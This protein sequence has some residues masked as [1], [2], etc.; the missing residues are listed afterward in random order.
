MT[1]AADNQPLLFRPNLAGQRYVYQLSAAY[2]RGLWI[3]DPDFAT[4]SD[5]EAWEKIR[6][7]A[8]FAAL[9]HKRQTDTAG[10]DWNFEPASDDDADVLAAEI[11]EDLF[12]E[13]RR[14]TQSRR[15]ASEAAFRGDSWMYIKGRRGTMTAGPDRTP[16]EYWY[17]SQLQHVDR[18]RFRLV[19]EHDE[20]GRVSTR[21]EMWSLRERDWL[22]LTHPEHFL[23]CVFDDTEQSLGYGRG[24][25][26]A[27]FFFWRAKAIAVA[28]GLQGLERWANGLVTAAIDGARIGSHTVTN[29]LIVD[30]WLEQLNKLRTEHF[31]AHDKRDE[32]KVHWPSSSGHELVKFWVEYFDNAARE[33]VLSRVLSAGGQESRLGSGREAEVEQAEKE[34]TSAVDRAQLAE[35]IDRSV[36]RL[37]WRLNQQQIRE[38]LEDA[39]LGGAKRP[40]FNLSRETAQT[41]P[42]ARAD[43]IAIVLGTQQVVVPRDWVHEQLDIPVPQEG[44]ETYGGEP[45]QPL[46]PL[47]FRGAACKPGETA[48][49][50][51]CDPAEGG[52]VKKAAVLAWKTVNAFPSI[53]RSLVEQTGAPENVVKAAFWVAFV[54]DTLV[55]GVPIAS[56]V[57]SG[58][59]L[60]I[61]AARELL[62]RR[63]ERAS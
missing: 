32:I 35:D 46:G 19:P 56:A 8:V 22:P 15:I 51:E 9:I 57:I 25:L 7:D 38:A 4:I 20:D 14:F 47:G 28:N 24:L 40:R 13:I 41:D 34:G 26:Q 36:G 58:T 44:E 5:T 52:K 50:T 59:A 12:R 11:M 49:K 3:Y 23:R 33:L 42:K 18:R 61:I 10:L 29:E 21:W 60:S 62:K 39:G 45:E 48:E 30:D 6:H 31:I 63:R 1:Q 55:P 2:Q 17:P 37:T 54:G 43:F 16:R 53:T 27:L